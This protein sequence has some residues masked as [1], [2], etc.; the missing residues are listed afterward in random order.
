MGI[1]SVTMQLSSVAVM[2][3]TIPFLR[4]IHLLCTS[5]DRMFFLFIALQ[6]MEAFCKKVLS[7]FRFGR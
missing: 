3:Y 5:A 4:C 2:L 7:G 1:R 6:R